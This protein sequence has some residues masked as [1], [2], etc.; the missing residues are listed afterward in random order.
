MPR[1]RIS[2]FAGRSS[3]QTG[4]IYL[5]SRRGQECARHG[6]VHLGHLGPHCRY[7]DH[8]KVPST[9]SRRRFVL[10]VTHWGQGLSSKSENKPFCEHPQP[11]PYISAAPVVS[12]FTALASSSASFRGSPLRSS[13]RRF[14]PTFRTESTLRSNTDHRTNSPGTW[15]DVCIDS[16]TTGLS[17]P[18]RS[19]PRHF[20]R[21]LN[22]Y[23]L[24]C[25]CR[26]IASAMPQLPSL[27]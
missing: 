4:C 7:E 17:R 26:G 11:A 10:S 27:V 24:Q 8:R 9:T 19:V 20:K 18:W 3:R 13:A 6:K 12:S 1:N 22:L 2:T 15:A 23:T 21:S 14:A 25:W 5:N 16:F